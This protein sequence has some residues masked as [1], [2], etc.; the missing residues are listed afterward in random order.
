MR[1]KTGLFLYSSKIQ[2]KN[3]R[4]S[5]KR[6]VRS[7]IAQKDQETTFGYEEEETDKNVCNHLFQCQQILEITKVA[8]QFKIETK[9]EHNLVKCC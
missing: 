9:I 3:E 2:R 5:G 1:K 6:T 7:Y 8:L 4:K